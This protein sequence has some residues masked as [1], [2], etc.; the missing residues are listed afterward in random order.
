M[1]YWQY[2]S[3]DEVSVQIFCFFLNQVVCLPIIELGEFFM[4]SYIILSIHGG[5]AYWSHL[6]S[7]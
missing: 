4:Y 7:R 1:A 2:I 6:G 5:V 3:F